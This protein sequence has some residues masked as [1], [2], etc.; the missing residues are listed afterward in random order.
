MVSLDSAEKNKEFAE[1]LDANFPVLSDSGK[2]IAKAYGVLGVTRLF[3]K[4]KTFYIDPEGLIRHV[5]N[6]IDPAS[7]GAQ[8][9]RNLADLGFPRVPEAP[10]ARRRPR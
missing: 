3:A 7:Y 6:D 4:R 2:Q 10:E 9:A 5:E 8:V 1:A